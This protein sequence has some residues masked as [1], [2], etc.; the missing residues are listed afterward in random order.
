M[1]SSA[2]GLTPLQLAVI[3]EL[4]RRRTKFFLTG[5]GVLVGWVLQHRATDDLDLFTTSDEA[6]AEADRLAR[7]IA[8][9]LA[10]RV[11]S[12]VSAPD[13]K[14]FLLTRGEE[15]VKLDFVRDRAPQLREKEQLAGLLMDPVCRELE[16]KLRA[17][18]A[19]RPE[20]R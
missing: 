16:V 15:A 8:A 3:A 7:G 20:A 9:A 2:K 18:A 11:Q 10:G 17:L 19:P 14:R 6:I 1:V 13:F 4:Q 5:G 12:L